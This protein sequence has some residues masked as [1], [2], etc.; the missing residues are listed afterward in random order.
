MRDNKLIRR[1]KM[2][3]VCLFFDGRNFHAGMKSANIQGRNVDMEKFAEWVVGRVAGGDGVLWGAHYYTGETTAI[4]AFLEALEATTGYFVHRKT[5]KVQYTTCQHCSARIEY[6]TEKEVDTQMVADMIRM[7]ASNAFDEMVLMSGDA[8]HSPGLEAVTM[9]GKRVWVGLWG[10]YGSGS[11]IVARSFGR[12]DLLEG[13]EKFT[14][15]GADHPHADEEGSEPWKREEQEELAE[16]IDVGEDAETNQALGNLVREINRAYEH[17]IRQGGYL[18]VSYFISRWKSP[19]IPK[20]STDRERLLDIALDN[21]LVVI[22]TMPSG[23]KALKPIPN[24]N[25]AEPKEE[26]LLDD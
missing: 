1:P 22:E 23:T 6:T 25:K 17:F 14:V 20:T 15:P 9:L 11:R 4:S 16:P 26:K 2:I 10:S 19:S 24:G 18:G 5:R 7:A 8:D 3:K 21:G 13:L 12:I